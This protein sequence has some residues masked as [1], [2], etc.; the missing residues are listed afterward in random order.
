MAETRRS[1]VEDTGDREIVITRIVDA[2]RELVWEAWTDPK[3]VAQWWGPRGFSTTIE[4]M[5]VRPGGVWRHTM[6]GPDGTD[7][8]N[9]CRF[10]EV[11]KPERIVFDHTGGKKGD[12]GA[13]H[14]ST[15]TFEPVGEKTKVVLR[16][17]FPSAAVREHVIKTYGAIEGGK[18]TLERMAEHLSARPSPEMA[19]GDREFLITREFDAP[20]ELVFKAWTEPRHLAQWWGPPPF[21]CPVCEMDVRV[22]GAYRVVMH[23]PEG[24]DYPITGVFREVTP[25]ERLAMTQDVSEHPKEWHDMVKPNRGADDKNPAGEMVCAVTFENVGGRTRLT[26][27]TRFQ[28]AAIRD[29][30]L[31]MGMNEGWSLSL[32]RLTKLLP[33]L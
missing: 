23:S 27:R 9:A 33:K 30:M 14:Q 28:S 32:E 2:P 8:P 10:T 29:A 4:E 24:V 19:A 1:L 26:V 12:A 25:P 20:R 18:Q 15:W 13:Q 5:D 6:H 31:K 17:V 22:G 3:H 16:M 11:V 7:Y 21:T